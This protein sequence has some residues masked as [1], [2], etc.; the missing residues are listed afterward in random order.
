MAALP[1]RVIN[2]KT[3]P[4]YDIPWLSSH[5]PCICSLEK[6]STLEKSLLK[7][8]DSIIPNK[9]L[10]RL[11]THIYTHLELEVQDIL[12]KLYVFP[13]SFDYHACSKVC[14]K[15]EIMTCHGHI[16]SCCHV[17]SMSMSYPPPMYDTRC[18]PWYLGSFS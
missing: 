9:C 5:I 3:H 4:E 6:P 1:T 7:S 12:L 15:F 16:M 14:G 10:Q 2:D 18:F 11:L 8:L 17:M 13:G